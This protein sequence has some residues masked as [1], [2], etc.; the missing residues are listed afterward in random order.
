MAFGQP[1]LQL[2]DGV[3]GGVDGS[4]DGALRGDFGAFDRAL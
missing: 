4:D 3:L 1:F 2:H